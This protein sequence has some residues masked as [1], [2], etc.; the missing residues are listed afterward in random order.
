MITNIKPMKKNNCSLVKS[1]NQ[2]VIVLIMSD[3]LEAIP[4][5]NLLSKTFHP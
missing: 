2:S 1:L 5:V 3:N 4:D